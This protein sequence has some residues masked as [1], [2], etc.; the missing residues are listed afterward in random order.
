MLSLVLELFA[1]V[2]KHIASRRL[3]LRKR[4]RS[5]RD[6]STKRARVHEEQAPLR[7]EHQTKPGN[8][9]RSPVNPGF[10]DTPSDTSAPRLEKYNPKDPDLNFSPTPDVQ[11]HL[12]IG[13][14][15]VTKRL[16]W[17][18]SQGRRITLSSTSR[19]QSES[20]LSPVQIVVACVHDLE[21][22]LLIA[23]LP[24]LVAS[25]NSAR[26]F[27]SSEEPV[28]LVPLPRGAENKLAKA[29]GLRR[30]SVLALEVSNLL[31]A[32]SS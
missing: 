7:F 23:H 29:I 21:S 28:K 22:P 9:R 12:V 16:E 4:K 14:N 5:G 25:C 10:S 30:V 17:Q 20:S 32:L 27:G 15:E 8:D 31:L 13:I 6:V 11:G 1:D 24:R 18:A 26:S 2:A 19:N 3:E